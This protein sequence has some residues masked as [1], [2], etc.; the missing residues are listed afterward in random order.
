MWMIDHT[1]A[2]R[3]Q[4]KLQNEK[5]L[6]MCDRRLLANMRKLD[7]ETLNEQLQPFL[8]KSEIKALLA[9]RDAIVKFFE[10]AVKEKGEGAVLYDLP[11]RP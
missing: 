7:E 11:A 10:N 6:I 4:L 8:T 3:L 9:R 5:N 1:R 2:F